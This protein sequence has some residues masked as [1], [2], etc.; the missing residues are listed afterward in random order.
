M[1]PV[2]ELLHT[3]GT[4]R[5]LVKS[6][7][8]PFGIFDPEKMSEAQKDFWIG[9]TTQRVANLWDAA[10]FIAD[11]PQEARDLLRNADK[12]TL[13]W[14]ERASPE[15]IDQLQYSVKFMV[16]AKLLGRVAWIMAATLFGSIITML[17][18][19]EKISAFLR[20]KT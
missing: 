14:L 20:A 9:M 10:D 1:A 12:K 7:M 16:A 13:R 18:F 5:D 19:W 15:D 11:L 17:A 8:P 3:T 4:G 2:C 6:A